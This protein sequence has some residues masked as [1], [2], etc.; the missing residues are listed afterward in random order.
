M[1]D[2]T[3]KSLMDESQSRKELVPCS[4]KKRKVFHAG[5][6]TSQIG[7]SHQHASSAERSQSIAPLSLS[8]LVK[9]ENPLISANKGRQNAQ[10]SSTLPIKDHAI[11]HKDAEILTQKNKDVQSTSVPRDD[12]QTRG[13]AF[14]IQVKWFQPWNLTKPEFG[15]FP[16]QV[17]PGMVTNTC[18][19]S[20]WNKSCQR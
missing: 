13:S 20:N 1:I 4:A 3:S 7:N 10:V 2:L 5:N 18:S 9:L 12:E 11:T 17:L 14:L 6:S 15:I 8:S 19:V 16:F